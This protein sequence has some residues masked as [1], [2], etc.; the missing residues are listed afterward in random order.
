MSARLWVTTSLVALLCTPAA[1]DAIS[2]QKLVEILKDKE[3]ASNPRRLLYAIGSQDLTL[4]RGE[5]IGALT[6][7]G[8]PVQARTLLS[9]TET[10]TSR[11]GRVKMDR[12]FSNGVQTPDGRTMAF[13]DE[14]AYRVD[15][16]DLVAVKGLYEAMTPSSGMRRLRTIRD[17]VP[18]PKPVLP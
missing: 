4:S 10:L 12:I 13:G 5:L 2:R 9:V 1:A 7:S 17:V 18:A 16:R 6:A 11:G 15:G 3:T 8:A 14:I